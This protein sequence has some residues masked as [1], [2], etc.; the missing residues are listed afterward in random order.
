[1]SAIAVER[2]GLAHAALLAA[3]HA[4]CFEKPWAAEEFVRLLETP[5]AFALTIAREGTPAGLSLAWVQADEAELLTFG[6]CANARR[7]GLASLL[8][9][10]TLEEAQALGAK[11]LFLEVAEPNAPARA[12]YA[13]LGFEEAGRR[14]GYYAGKADALILRR[15]TSVLD[16]ANAS[17]HI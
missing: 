12:L 4:E 9:A 6:V 1:M 14:R 15:T 2:A 16:S 17:A 5:G 8:L 11:A 13:K 7:R 10:V 3:V